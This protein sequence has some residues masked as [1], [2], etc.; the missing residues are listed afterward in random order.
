MQKTPRSLQSGPGHPP[1]LPDCRSGPPVPSRGASETGRQCPAADFRGSP[2]PPVAFGTRRAVAARHAKSPKGRPAHAAPPAQRNVAP[3]S[4]TRGGKT[5]ERKTAPHRWQNALMSLVR[6]EN[7]GQAKPDLSGLLQSYPSP[8]LPSHQKTA[9][10]RAAACPCRGTSRQRLASGLYPMAACRVGRIPAPWREHPRPSPCKSPSLRPS[11]RHAPRKRMPAAARE[12]FGTP[13]CRARRIAAHARPPAGSGA[14]D[15]AY[16]CLLGQIPRNDM[17]N[18][19]QRGSPNPG[20][21]SP[22]CPFRRCV[23]RGDHGR[24]RKRPARTCP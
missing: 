22:G 12:R 3:P 16:T 1:S 21:P 8:P 13:A 9:W 6:P 17:P 7:M 19:P 5:R 15:G 11:P 10:R 20:P 14:H 24:R 23:D 18:L 4:A 2:A